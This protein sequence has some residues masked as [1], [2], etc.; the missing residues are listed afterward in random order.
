VRALTI[1]FGL[2]GNFVAVT[3][4][5]L[6]ELLSRDIP[7]SKLLLDSG[8]AGAGLTDSASG[9]DGVA[10]LDAIWQLLIRSAVLWYGALALGTLFWIS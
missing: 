2:V 9:E 3:Q 6:H 8:L 7:A 1:S 4:T 5:L 10:S